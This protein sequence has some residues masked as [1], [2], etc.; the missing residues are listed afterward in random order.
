MIATILEFAVVLLIKQKMG[1]SE[2][3]ER[4]KTDRGRG[5]HSKNVRTKEMGGKIGII[6]MTKPRLHKTQIRTHS[7]TDRIDT[8]SL[9]IFMF[10]YIMFNI[11]Y[12]K[13][14]I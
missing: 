9:C 1:D 2:I 8:A 14:Y 6:D 4:D 5:C 12:M 3:K 7:L 13:T 10:C 11:V